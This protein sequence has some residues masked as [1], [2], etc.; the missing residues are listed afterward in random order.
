MSHTVWFFFSFLYVWLNLIEAHRLWWFWPFTV[1]S[2]S[3]SL[4]LNCNPR[5]LIA[6]HTAVLQLLLIKVK[7]TSIRSN[8]D[9]KGWGEFLYLHIFS[10]S[11]M[12]CPKTSYKM[13]TK[14]N[15][16]KKDILLLP[17]RKQQK[18]EILI[19]S[20]IS[21]RKKKLS[22]TTYYLLLVT[23]KIFL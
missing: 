16:V 9:G 13:R 1:Y 10:T 3:Y 11:I 20:L 5:L 8:R 6:S 2:L 4:H 23:F 12:S 22:K 19:F 14:K 18:T 15:P 7:P 17:F 21:L